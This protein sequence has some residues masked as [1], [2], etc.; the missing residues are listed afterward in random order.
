MSP[1]ISN[2]S[3][4]SWAIRA[5]KTW[6]NWERLVFGPTVSQTHRSINR[7]ETRC[8]RPDLATRL[9]WIQELYPPVVEDYS[10]LSRFGPFFNPCKAFDRLTLCQVRDICVDPKSGLSWIP[11]GDAIQESVAGG[12]VRMQI[13]GFM[14]HRPLVRAVQ[15]PADGPYLAMDDLGYF[16]F[17]AESLPLVITV[18]HQMPDVGLLLSSRAGPY[19]LDALAIL[20]ERL[21]RKI[22]VYTHDRPLRMPTLLIARKVDHSGYC[23]K[24]FVR[25]LQATLARPLTPDGPPGESI[26][27]GRR[28]NEKRSSDDTARVDKLT[29]DCGWTVL[30]L[31]DLSFRQQIQRLMNARRLGGTHGAG[32]VN[33]VWCHHLEQVTEIH[34]PGYFNDCYAR[35]AVN[36]GAV[37]RPFLPE[38]LGSPGP[39]TRQN[40]DTIEAML[41]SR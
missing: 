31:Q 27:V 15:G 29:A 8:Y 17:V 14:E 23:R 26:W 11:G 4:N 39:L 12:L 3:R 19:V 34:L 21:D 40:L 33:M 2:L 22:K 35:L 37:Y 30:Y 32:L 6:K 16:H 10:C 41:K 25:T 1:L 13:P 5:R 28:R 38:N 20:E 9:D 24:E 36:C 18:L 7:I